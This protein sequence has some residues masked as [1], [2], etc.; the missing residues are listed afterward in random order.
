[1]SSRRRNKNNKSNPPSSQFVFNASVGDI[2]NVQNHGK[3]GSNT[4]KGNVHNYYGDVTIYSDDDI[5]IKSKKVT[6]S[7]NTTEK[8]YRQ[9]PLQ[10]VS[11]YFQK[12][13]EDK[14]SNTHDLTKHVL[15]DNRCW[16]ND[17][18]TMEKK[19][20]NN[21]S[22]CKQVS[23]LLCL[24]CATYFGMLKNLFVCA[25]CVSHVKRKGKALDTN[26]QV[27]TIS[28]P[29]H[30]HIFGFIH[31]HMDINELNLT[32]TILTVNLRNTALNDKLLMFLL[33]EQL[34]KRT[35]N[36]DPS[37][38]NT[39]Y[40]VT[41]FFSIEEISSVIDALTLCLEKLSIYPPKS[42]KSS[43]F[44]EV[45]NLYKCYKEFF[46]S[47][48]KTNIQ[49]ANASPVKLSDASSDKSSNASS[50]ESS[51]PVKSS[52]ASSDK[53]SSASSDESS[54]VSSDESSNISTDDD[55]ANVAAVESPNVLPDEQESDDI[56]DAMTTISNEVQSKKLKVSMSPG[57]KEV[58]ISDTLLKSQQVFIPINDG[59]LTPYDIDISKLSP[60]DKIMSEEDTDSRLTPYDISNL[61]PFD[62]IMSEEDIG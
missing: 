42:Q 13:C 34:N 31:F 44:K 3:N 61:S 10:E 49:N 52:D 40:F 37:K 5:Q 56:I 39:T 11:N 1:M 8:K 54:D 38:N 30:P 2:V 7:S 62:E 26:R 22:I 24:T 57:I 51:A 55:S 23:Q 27:L 50:D 36:S 17:H 59:R 32:K 16:H 58:F 33:M 28:N 45:V 15:V 19:F 60:F 9:Y 12:V 47:R 48:M 53:S 46:I 21:C 20:N 35:G 14:A 25:D 43:T 6:S 29:L 4:A 18:T 41:S